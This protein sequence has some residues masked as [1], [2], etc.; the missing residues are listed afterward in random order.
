MLSD[1][2]RVQR[3]SVRRGLSHSRRH[4]LSEPPPALTDRRATSMCTSP[5]NVTFGSFR[6]FVH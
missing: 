1:L 6:L 4:P 5:S 3:V 2:V